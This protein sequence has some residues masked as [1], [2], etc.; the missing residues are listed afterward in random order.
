M[1][2]VEVRIYMY[3][4]PVKCKA[5]RELLTIVAERGWVEIER[6][7]NLFNN[8]GWGGRQILKVHRE[9]R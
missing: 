9:E 3:V 7:M 8:L 6:A 4:V 1:L 5:F 2:Y